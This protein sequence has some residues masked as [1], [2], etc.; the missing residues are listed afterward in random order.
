MQKKALKYWTTALGLA[1]SLSATP[2][3]AND[4][5]VNAAAAPVKEKYGVDVRKL[6]ASTCALCHNN[7]GLTAGGRGGGPKL[8]GTTKDKSGVIDRITN[9]KAGLMPAF[10]STLKEEQI[11]ALA[12]YIKALPAN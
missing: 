12:E 4:E 3:L 11:Q 8:A 1:A 10:K 5:I 7:Y 9:G 2:A 6:F